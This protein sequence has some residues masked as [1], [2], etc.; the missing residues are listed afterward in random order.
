M[1]QTAA[2]TVPSHSLHRH[3]LRLLSRLSWLELVGLALFMVLLFLTIFGE[4]LAPYPT[5]TADPS[6]I[7]LPPN[8][9]HWFG[10]DNNGMDVLSRILA[11][12][13]TDVL[14]AVIAS[15]ISVA[16]GV[17]LGV[18]VGYFEGTSNRLASLLGEAFLRVLDVIQAFPV[19]ILAMVLVAIRG[20]NVINVVAAIAFVNIPV[21]L[22]LVR[23]EI[24][25][26]RRRPYAEAARVIGNH[27]LGIAF[28]H[29]LPNALPP[30]IVQ[31]S[32]TIGFAILLTA[33][34]SFVGAGVA[35][36]TPELGSMISTG[37]KSL[38]IDQWWP[39]LF[40]GIALG[41]TVFSFGVAGE[42]FGK[43]LDPSWRRADVA[44]RRL[45]LG[46]TIEH[47][48]SDATLQVAGPEPV[49]PLPA[50]TMLSD[51]DAD[52]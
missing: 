12:P 24:L 3:A 50:T 20:A 6:H 27:D 21:F 44:V 15:F 18:T 46:V 52:L 45:D 16:V 4:F 39:S 51:T 37:A 29:L 30:V 11:A 13:R 40:P 36:P 9:A 48:P 7:L 41:M 19:F 47:A 22:R 17:P 28:K 31:I 2:P 10:T 25:S 32:V 33:G 8:A 5:Q 43:L 49:I 34:L 35:P 1:T 23:S 26:L 38:I 42:V 14:I